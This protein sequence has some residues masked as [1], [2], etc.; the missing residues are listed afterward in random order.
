MPENLFR[1]YVTQTQ[2]SLTLTKRMVDMI[3]VL[4]EGIEC[5]G[6]SYFLTTVSA[7]IMRGLAEYDCDEKGHKLTVAGKLVAELL[8][9]A[10]LF[11]VSEEGNS[12]VHAH[13][14]YLRETT[15]KGGRDELAV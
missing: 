12:I 13:N 4:D 8:R 7:L 3:C 14:A 11:D 2:F 5:H 15:Q 9:E 10:E 1:E 6:Y